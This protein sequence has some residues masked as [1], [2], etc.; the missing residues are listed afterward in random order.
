MKEPD[1]F[2]KKL[3]ELIEIKMR[4]DAES[5]DKGQWI[6]DILSACYAPTEKS[7]RELSLEKRQKIERLAAWAGQLSAQY[8]KATRAVN[9]LINP[10]NN[11]N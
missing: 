7:I 9:D 11:K 5:E 1:E 10:K 2:E 3:R 6:A 4:E 8:I